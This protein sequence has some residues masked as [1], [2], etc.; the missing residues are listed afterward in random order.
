MVTQED[1]ANRAFYKV[2]PVQ[3]MLRDWIRSILIMN[4]DASVY[5]MVPVYGYSWSVTPHLFITLDNQPSEPIL[6]DRNIVKYPPN[7]I[8]GPRLVN[9][10]QDLGLRR[11]VVGIAFKPGG[12]ARVLGLPADE[13]VNSRLDA[14]LVWNKDISGL[15]ER[16]KN[17]KDDKELFFVTEQ[18]LM[19]KARLLKS[20]VPF[21]RAIEELILHNGNLPISTVAD[22]AGVG[23]RQL[24]RSFIQKVGI[25]PKLFSKITR[26]ANACM[27]KEA[28]P[29]APWSHIAYGFGYADQAHLIHDFKR[30]S[31]NTPTEI[32]LRIKTS[33]PTLVTITEGRCRF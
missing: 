18:F 4:W 14:S 17:A 25:T 8:V 3:P 32:D 27:Y 6:P 16:L 19:Q 30:F 22:L 7:F 10:T 31:G 26:F 5:E 23:L 13:L 20:M 28:H 29:G 12:I 9:E 1:L 11:R 2:Y 33:I 15:S 21:D 24:E